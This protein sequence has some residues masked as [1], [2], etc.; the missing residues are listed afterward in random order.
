MAL[1]LKILEWA[2]DSKNTLVH[3]LPLTRGG[4][5]VNHKSKLIYFS[6]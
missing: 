2:D 3:K 1:F 6:F 5:D 4:R